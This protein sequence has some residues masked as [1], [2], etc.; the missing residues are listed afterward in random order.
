MGSPGRESNEEVGQRPW[1][2]GRKSGLKDLDGV[3]AAREK[4]MGRPGLMHQGFKILPGPTG[5]ALRGCCSGKLGLELCDD[6]FYCAQEKGQGFWGKGE[7]G[8]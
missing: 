1:Q 5:V 4:D 2:R 7:T 8:T 6:C 3:E